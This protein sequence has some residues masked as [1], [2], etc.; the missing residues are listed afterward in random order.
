MEEPGL[1]LNAVRVFGNACSCSVL[2]SVF[3]SERVRLNVFGC[4]ERLFGFGCGVILLSLSVIKLSEHL[5]GL[6]ER[7]FGHIPPERSVNMFDLNACSCSVNAVRQQPWE[8]RKF[9]T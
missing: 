4:S 9:V 5:F 7:L 6:S 1:Q 3:E 2:C 8:E